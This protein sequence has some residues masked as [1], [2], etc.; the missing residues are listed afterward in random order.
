MARHWRSLATRSVRVVYV[1]GTFLVRFWYNCD[2]ALIHH[3]YGRYALCTFLV[4]F[5]Y[6]FGTVPVPR[7][8]PFNTIPDQSQFQGFSRPCASF[9]TSSILLASI[10]TSSILVASIRILASMRALSCSARLRFG[11]VT[12]GRSDLRVSCVAVR[13]VSVRPWH[14]TGAVL[15]CDR[16]DRCALC[17]FLVRCWYVFGTF[18]VL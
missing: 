14:A 15:V 8:S 5:W 17:T 9:R 18:L 16:Y 11:A 2:A 1:F 4:R 12:S 7:K 13:T 3:R 10:R 6:V